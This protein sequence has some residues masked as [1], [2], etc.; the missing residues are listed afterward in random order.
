MPFDQARD[1]VRNL[2]VKNQSEYR[3]WVVGRLERRGLAARP[4]SIPA[5]PDQ[6]YSDQWRGFNDFLGTAKPKNVGRVWRPFKD[7]REYVRS[8]GLS[9]YLEYKEWSKGQLKNKPK[10]PDDIP[11]HPY[12][13]YAKEKQWKGVPDFLGSKPSGKY[14]QMWPYSKAR[15]F[16]RRLKLTSAKEYANWAAGAMAELAKKPAEIP[17]APSKKYRN[18]WRDWDDWLGTGKVQSRR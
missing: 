12:G 6:I 8:L 10:F 13:A 15:S 3:K 11:A 4:T 14:V 9:S 16:V 1:F 17:V 5:N 2:G 18:Q 7:A